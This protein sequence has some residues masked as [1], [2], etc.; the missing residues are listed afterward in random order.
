MLIRLRLRIAKTALLNG[1]KVVA[2]ARDFKKTQDLDKVGAYTISLDIT[3]S[4]DEIEKIITQAIKK[5]SSIEILV[6]NAE[7]NLKGAVEEAK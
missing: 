2:T 7:Y 5:F 6:S 4:D 3:T 1:H